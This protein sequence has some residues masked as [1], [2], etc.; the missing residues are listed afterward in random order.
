MVWLS[1]AAMVGCIS[2]CMYGNGIIAMKTIVRYMK[3]VNT[4]YVCEYSNQF[5]N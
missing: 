1:S 2:I 3:Y 5:T 4:F